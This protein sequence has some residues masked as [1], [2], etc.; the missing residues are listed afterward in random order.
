MRKV[1]IIPGEAEITEE[2]M[3]AARENGCTEIAR[4]IPPRIK[5]DCMIQEL[6]YVYE[7]PDVATTPARDVL[8][9][10]DSLKTKVAALE[11]AKAVQ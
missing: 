3:N 5:S 8:A 4:G 7:E 10:L 2:V 1:Y 6:P 11:A 9:E